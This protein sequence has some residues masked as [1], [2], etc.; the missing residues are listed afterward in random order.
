MDEPMM[1][2]EV[3]V[4]SSPRRTGLRHTAARSRLLPLVLLAVIA[5]LVITVALARLFAAG[6]PAMKK[7]VL[8]KFAD[9][10]YAR[11]LNRDD[12]VA[13]LGPPTSIEPLQPGMAEV[14]R[15]DAVYPTLTGSDAFRL[16]LA[17]DR[18]E[19]Q[20]FVVAG[21]LFKNDHVVSPYRAYRE[22]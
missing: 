21:G 5:L 9:F 7:D 13:L 14:C 2:V 19:P 20:G 15:W 4:T 18:S 10:D 16:T 6:Q 1:R 8:L 12:V 3:D 17:F 11:T 22:R